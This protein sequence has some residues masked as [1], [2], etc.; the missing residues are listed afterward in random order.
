MIRVSRKKQ[1]LFLD[2]SHHSVRFLLLAPSS[3]V[4]VVSGPAYTCPLTLRHLMEL[5]HIVPEV[6]QQING[7]LDVI[8]LDDEATLFVS[9]VFGLREVDG[10][11]E[12]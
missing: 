9:H 11:L 10:D 2:D 12:R 7:N 4:V 8:S 3:G 1:P 5:I 6:F